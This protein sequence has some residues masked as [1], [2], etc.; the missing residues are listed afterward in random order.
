MAAQ[1]SRTLKL[2][3]LAD[4]AEFTKGIN[5]ASK[6]TQ[7]IGD[8]FEAFGKKAALAFARSAMIGFGVLICRC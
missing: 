2:S 4:V 8:Q 5:T 7:S 1:G 3:L 6:D